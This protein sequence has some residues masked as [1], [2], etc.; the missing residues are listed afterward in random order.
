[1]R[2]TKPSKAFNKCIRLANYWFSKVEAEYNSIAQTSRGYS[3]LALSIGYDTGIPITD[4][5]I[6]RD[7]AS[8]DWRGGLIPFRWKP[9]YA[10]MLLFGNDAILPS[11]D[12]SYKSIVFGN[13]IRQW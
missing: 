11:G 2:M 12:G 10:Q 13:L 4:W 9:G 7:E 5:K 3:G 1:M 8:A 6:V